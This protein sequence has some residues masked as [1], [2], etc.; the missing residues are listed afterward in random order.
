MRKLI[1]LLVLSLPA[2]AQTFTAFEVFPSVAV[3]GVT[4]KIRLRAEDAFGCANP[5]IWCGVS[6]VTIG[7]VQAP[8][9]RPTNLTAEIEVDLPDLQA[10]TVAD[11][12][13]ADLSGNIR[14]RNAALR[15]ISADAPYSPEN[16][17]RVLI[18][19][20]YD[21]PGQNGAVWDTDVWVMNGSNYDIAF[22]RGPVPQ[23]ERE[24]LTRIEDAAPNGYVLYPVKNAVEDLAI[25]VLVRDRSRQS[26]ALGTEIPAVREREFKSRRILLMNVPSDPK[27]RLTLRLYAFERLQLMDWLNY[28]LFDLETGR[29]VAFD[30]VTFHPPADET[31]PWHATVDLTAKHPDIVRHGR[32]MRLS[33]SPVR[34][35]PNSRFWAFLT[36]T[37]NETQHV[38]A[39]TPQP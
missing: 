24:Q 22:M 5:P 13:V 4:G 8:A 26:E 31:M 36:V 23:L 12:V 1:L 2:A 10:G 21:G 18:P 39:I 30:V 17:D 11:I 3:K 15:V 25:N 27:F 32:P 16:F 7:G 37:N 29:Q 28:W 33:I 14:R 9:V 6:S 34:P 19:V 35:D 20:I 38:T